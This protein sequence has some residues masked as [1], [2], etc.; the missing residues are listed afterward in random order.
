MRVPL[1]THGPTL[2]TI[3]KNHQFATFFTVLPVLVVQ[4]AY[5]AVCSN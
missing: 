1:A 2:D 4:V 3:I 5:D